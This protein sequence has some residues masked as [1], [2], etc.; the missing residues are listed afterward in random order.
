MQERADGPEVPPDWARYWPVAAAIV[1]NAVPIIGVLV[2]GWSAFTLIFLY[3]LENVVVGVRTLIS[4]LLSGAASAGGERAGTLFMAAFFCVHYGLFCYGHGVFVVMVFGVMQDAALIPDGQWVNLPAV[5]AALFHTQ[6]N[7]LQGFVSVIL[8]QGVM[9]SLFIVRGDIQ[10]MTPQALMSAPYPRIMTLHV[11]IIA[12][13]FLLAM[14]HQPL[15]G[16]VLLALIKTGYDV[17]AVMGK[18]KPGA[19][20]SPA[21]SAARSE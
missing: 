8:W 14:L 15:W 16:L 5:A 20:L 2:W 12:G 1:L 6:Q 13:G 3:W 18:M 11:V 9:L 19:E 21:A 17:A 7:L 10:R 4:M